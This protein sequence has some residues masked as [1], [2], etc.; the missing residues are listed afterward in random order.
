MKKLL[1]L[2][3]FVV[4]LIMTSAMSYT[5]GLLEGE[6]YDMYTLVGNLVGAAVTSPVVFFLAIKKGRLKEK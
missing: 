4:I 2:G 1:L 6:D 3:I 5:I